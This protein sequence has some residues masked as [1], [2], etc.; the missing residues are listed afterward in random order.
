MSAFRKV[1]L[2]VINII[3]GVL[4]NFAA[5]TS[6]PFH[7]NGLVKVPR[8]NTPDD[9]YKNAILLS[10]T[11]SY[12]KETSATFGF[13]TLYQFKPKKAGHLTR[14]SNIIGSGWASLMGQFTIGSRHE[15]LTTGEKIYLH[16]Q[17]NYRQFPEYFFGVGASTTP[18]NKMT[19]SSK[20]F[21]LEEQIY[22]KIANRLFIGPQLR[23]FRYYDLSLT[24]ASAD[25]HLTD[26]YGTAN[27]NNIGLG[28]GILCDHRDLI[29]TPSHGY[30]IAGTVTFH[31]PLWGSDFNFVKLTFDGRKFFDFQTA[32]KSV[33]A[34]QFKTELNLGDVPLTELSQLGGEMSMRGYMLGRYRDRNS[35]QSQ[36]E[37]RQHLVWR[38]GLTA[39]A[40]AGTVAPQPSNLV[41]LNNI[42][43]AAGV[44]FRFNINR[45]DPANLRIDYGMTEEGGGIYI[46]FGEAF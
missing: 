28:L 34:L 5:A 8:T 45:Q 7:L 11:F 25:Y 31:Q 21:Q 41:R 42:K 23:F 4:P 30:Y 33:L 43:T 27:Q 16:G 22:F 24:D 19:L 6:R 36:I 44:G 14:P 18:E 29:M 38:I 2:L 35:F 3:V 9:H 12:A 15:I 10:P 46:S 40:G 37:F 32:G 13:F 17:F 39:F 20:A 26:F 1:F